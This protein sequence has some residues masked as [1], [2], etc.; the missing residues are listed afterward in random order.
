MEKTG[1]SK[2]EDVAQSD[3][4]SPGPFNV[5]TIHYLVRLMRK[6]DLGQIDL[7]EGERRIRLRRGAVV[8]TAT[9]TVGVGIPAMIPPPSTPPAASPP[10]PPAEPPKPSRPLVEIKSPI[11]G[12]FYAKPAPD[13]EDYV[14]IGSKVTPDTIV[15]KVEA[16]KIF[17]DIKAETTGTIVEILV[18]NGQPVE[19]DTVLFRV[20]PNL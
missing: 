20:D 17:N 11:V 2:G 10:P 15:C 16:M 8:A 18:K 7:Q 14:R 9:P 19:Y 12:T 1:F 3:D 13:K 5:R 4:R 6:Y